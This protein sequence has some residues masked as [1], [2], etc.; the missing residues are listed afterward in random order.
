MSLYD[1]TISTCQDLSQAVE[2]GISPPST[3][4]INI[5]VHQVQSTAGT[6]LGGRGRQPHESLRGEC[7][8]LLL[9]PF[10][11]SSQATEG[12]HGE[13][14]EKRPLT[15]LLP[16]VGGT[17]FNIRAVFMPDRHCIHSS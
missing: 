15:D 7:L 17:V 6:E 1:F 9:Y 4:A 10:C 13:M 12:G 14:E 3:I 16:D 5:A 2:E 11:L 8:S